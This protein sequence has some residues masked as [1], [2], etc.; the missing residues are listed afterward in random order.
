M[1]ETRPGSQAGIETETAEG[2]LLAF[3]PGFL[4]K[5]L[6]KVQ[7]SLEARRRCGKTVY[8]EM[9]IRERAWNTHDTSYRPYEGQEG[10]PKCG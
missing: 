8:F 10:G 4:S 2:C 9:D 6:W 7:A 5:A 3:P 1:K